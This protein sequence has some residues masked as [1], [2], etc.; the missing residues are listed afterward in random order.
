MCCNNS[1]LVS[2]AGCQLTTVVVFSMVL[3]FSPYILCCSC[4]LFISLCLFFL[5]L[6]SNLLVQ[7]M[8][9]NFLVSSM[10]AVLSDLL[11]QKRIVIL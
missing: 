10:I 7:S 2:F 4:V 1:H 8:E 3:K 5:H 11:N 6:V 9:E